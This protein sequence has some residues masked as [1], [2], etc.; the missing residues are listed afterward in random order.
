[1]T[2]SLLDKVSALA[3]EISEHTEAAQTEANK[4]LPREGGWVSEEETDSAPAMAANSF[5]Q[6]SRERLGTRARG[7]FQA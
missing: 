3:E 1:M 7:L 6:A 4:S 5:G 2:I